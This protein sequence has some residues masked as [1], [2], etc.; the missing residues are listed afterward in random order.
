MSRPCPLRQRAAW[1]SAWLLAAIAVVAAVVRLAGRASQARDRLAFQFAPPPGRLGEAAAVAAG[2]LRLAGAVL[3]AALLVGL[4]PGTRP[5]L[6]LVIAA[7][8]ALNAAAAGLG[9]GSYGRRL[10]EAVAAHAALEFAAFA[11]AGGA[12]LAARRGPLDARRLAAAAAA[13]T[14]LLGAAALVETYVQLGGHS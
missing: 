3:L 14:C 9:L 1:A 8:A 12:Y 13:C 5:A 2:N 4:R 6:D 10:L 7:L 11:L